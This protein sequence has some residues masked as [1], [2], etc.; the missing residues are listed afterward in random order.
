MIARVLNAY[1]VEL[2]KASR[3]ALTYIGP[4]LVV[5]AVLCMPLVRRVARDGTSDYAF[6]AYA[7][8]MAL[9]L[10]GLL[11]LLAYC[12]SQVA[13]E[14]GSGTIRM[15]LVRPLRRH[16]F[17]L[18]KL[19]LGMTYAVL[20]TFSAAA[21]SWATVLAFG[22]LG[23]VSYGGEVIYTSGAML[24]TYLVAAGLS[25]LPLFAAV[26]YATMIS[27]FTR[28]TGAAV[29]AAVGIWLLVDIV[30]YPLRIAPLVF[31]TYI[32]APWQVFANRC[33]GFEASWSP[34]ALYGAATSAAWST[35]LVSLA[36]LALARRN[37]NA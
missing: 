2:S 32:E 36:M 29:G 14:L 22:D 11:V 20:L 10:L 7:T 9:N 28:S 12:A 6:I 5:L 31:S 34:D 15:V 1:M 13:A 26:A 4:V 37:L 23:G 21:T 27:T 30:K 33:G 35:V 8:P 16:E 17:L 3:Q 18:A 25:L 24:T 19:L